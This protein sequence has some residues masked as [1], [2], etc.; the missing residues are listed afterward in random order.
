MSLLRKCKLIIFVYLYSFAVLILISVPVDKSFALEVEIPD[1]GS[2]DFGTPADSTD[3]DNSY[4]PL[5][6][7]TIFYYEAETDDGLEETITE[8]TSDT[9]IILGITTVVV[10][11]TAFL[12][13]TLI[14]DTLD[15][16]AQDVDGNVWYFGEDTEGYT[17]D[18]NGILI[19]TSTEGSWEAGI[20]VAGTGTDAKAGI[21]MLADPENGLSYMQEFYEDEAEDMAK[22]S[23]LNAKVSIEYGDYD[24]CLKTKEWTPL[25][26]GSVE[27]KYYATGVGLVYVEENHGKT[28]KVELVGIDHP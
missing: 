23:N 15:W 1:I 19:D 21:V 16:Y 12:D 20:D 24:D 27:Y 5:I 9:K 8:V 28:V 22:V 3:I 2:V 17:Y 25:E 14:E 10:H 13:G 18:E 7:G 26:S 11:D 4:M 6:P